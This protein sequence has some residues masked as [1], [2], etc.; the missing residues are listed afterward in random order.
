MDTTILL[1]KKELRSQIKMSLNAIQ[2]K[3]TSLNQEVYKVLANKKEYEKAF[4][5]VDAEIKELVN[6]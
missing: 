3:L 4:I 6:E 2:Y 5:E 1:A